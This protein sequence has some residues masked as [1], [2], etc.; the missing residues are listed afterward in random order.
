MVIHA[1]GKQW[2]EQIKK[3]TEQKKQWGCKRKRQGN[4]SIGR[5]RGWRKEGRYK[6]ERERRKQVS[7]IFTHCFYHK[8]AWASASHTHKWKEIHRALLFFLPLFF[9]YSYS[10]ALCVSLPLAL[11]LFWSQVTINFVCFSFTFQVFS[12][13]E[14]R[15]RKKWNRESEWE[16]SSSKFTDI[17]PFIMD[18]ASGKGRRMEKTE[19]KEKK[20]DM[21]MSWRS[22]KESKSTQ[23][24]RM[25]P[26]Q[27]KKS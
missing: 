15:K 14:K 1:P 16:S 2:D 5:G 19:S 27:K 6:E 18:K 4:G 26:S 23:K 17:R 24:R 8:A 3:A 25:R 7:L 13:R 9:F 12:S 21:G 10:G 20:C 22:K 11:S